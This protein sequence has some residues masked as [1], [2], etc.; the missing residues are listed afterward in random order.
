MKKG[1][2]LLGVMLALAVGSILSGLLMQSLWQLSFSLKKVVNITSVDTRI[3][4]VQNILEKELSGAFIPQLILIDREAATDDETKKGQADQLKQPNPQEKQKKVTPI[5]PP[6]AFYSKNEDQNLQMLTFI[7]CNPLEV[8]NN[9]KP[10]IV[11][12]MYTLV[13]DKN[14]PEAFELH[15]QASP[16][17]M[18]LKKF[19]SEVVKGLVVINGIKS[20]TTEFLALPKKKK[21]EKQNKKETQQKKKTQDKENPKEKEKKEFIRI[22]HWDV[23][24]QKEN[25]S[26]DK[27]KDEKKLPLLP[28][29]IKIKITL[30]GHNN[31]QE[32]IYSF[33]FAPNYGIEQIILEGIK[34]MQ[35]ENRKKDNKE[36]KEVDNQ[37]KNIMDKNPLSSNLQNKF[38]KWQPGAKSTSSSSP[39]ARKAIT[40][41]MEA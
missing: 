25:K 1:F 27:D 17:I 23:E 22:D 11:R 15:R 16:N 7:T 14:R 39:S 8:Y 21:S 29:F 20:I 24:D 37:I 41:G 26:D 31:A 4:V 40:K 9:S 30:F 5:T 10:R 35:T 34:P 12:I 3:A 18:K 13:S 19:E 28:Q 38:D 36:S 6:K 2:S 33:T 32:V